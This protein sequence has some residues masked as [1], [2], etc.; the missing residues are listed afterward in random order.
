MLKG[1]KV[2]EM[3]RRFG[4]ASLDIVMLAIILISLG[5]ACGT[6]RPTATPKPTATPL[7]YEFR[8]GGAAKIT[9]YDGS[10]CGNLEAREVDSS[11][12]FAKSIAKAGKTLSCG[13]KSL[14]GFKTEALSDYFTFWVEADYILPK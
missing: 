13:G 8:L 3:K 11:A 9:Y 6:P 10:S 7:R 4:I 2:L 14:I 12:P 5:V 1:R